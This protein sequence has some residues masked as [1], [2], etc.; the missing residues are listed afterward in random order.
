MIKQHEGVIVL[1]SNEDIMVSFIF[2][3]DAI[4]CAINISDL[5]K[6]ITDKYEYRLALVTGNPV[7]K[8]GTDLFEETKDKIKTIVEIGLKNIICIDTITKSIVDKTQNTP[9]FYSNIFKIVSP[10]NFFLL[11]KMHNLCND[12]LCSTDFN[13]F[14]LN[15]ILGLSK[16][17]AYRKIKL[18]TGMASNKLIQELR[19]RQSLKSI[20]QNNKTVTEISY[21]LG[22]NSPTYFTRVFKKRFGILPTS[23]AKNSIQELNATK[24]KNN[25]GFSA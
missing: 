10:I 6:S 8:G 24:C 5:L 3:S 18:S 7:D 14:R 21:D 22:F 23:F 17:Q 19:L 2:A 16:S 12:E 9:K 25:R 15:T 11:K 1:E 20:K 13:I 4:A